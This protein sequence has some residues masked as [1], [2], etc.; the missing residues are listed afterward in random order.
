MNLNPTDCA[1]IDCAAYYDRLIFQIKCKIQDDCAICLDTLVNRSV[2]YLPCK[3]YFHASCIKQTFA[4]KIYTC[5]LCRH[6]LMNSLQK[7]GHKFNEENDN[8]VWSYFLYSYYYTRAEAGAGAG[9]GAGAE[10]SE[11]GGGASEA[12]ASEAGALDEDEDWAGAEASEVGAVDDEDGDT[13]RVRTQT[14]D[15][16][17]RTYYDDNTPLMVRNYI[18]YYVL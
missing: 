8:E 13:V 2:I 11:V 1:A 15:D 14:L 4:E 18:I 7:V 6:N 16:Y 10:A 12:G 9:A 3:H 17:I 5:P